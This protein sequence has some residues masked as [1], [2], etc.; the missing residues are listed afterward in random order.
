VLAPGAPDQPL[1]LIDARDLARWMLDAFQD[2][3]RGVFNAVSHTGHATM[4]SLLEAC[5]DVTGSRAELVWVPAGEVLAAE[6]EPW[7]ELPIWM[8]PGTEGDSLHHANV[9]RAYAAGLRPRPVEQ[10]VS[11]TWSWLRERGLEAPQR[12]DR[13]PVGLSLEREQALLASWRSR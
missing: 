2:G 9:E 5:R 3:H 8:A 6:I 1:Q 11:D 7:T 10:T 13:P 12:P 4:G